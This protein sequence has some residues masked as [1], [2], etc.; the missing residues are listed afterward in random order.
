M[1]T[2]LSKYITPLNTSLKPLII[3][4]IVF[5]LFFQALISTIYIVA[6][7]TTF[8]LGRWIILFHVLLVVCAIVSIILLYSALPRSFICWK[9]FR[10]AKHFICAS[11]ALV[12][13]NIFILYVVNFASNLLF[14]Q[15]VT[16]KVI[17]EYLIGLNEWAIITR[18]IPAGSTILTVFLLLILVVWAGYFVF[19]KKLL[20]R[21]KEDY[22]LALPKS[23]NAPEK[24]RGGG[25]AIGW[26][27]ISLMAVIVIVI[28]IKSS[29]I[30]IR[31]PIVTFFSTKKPSVFE[32]NAHR[33]AVEKRDE[34]IR[35]SF[36]GNPLIS[37]R[38]NVV[39]IVVDCLRA[40]HLPLYGYQRPTTPFLSKL[41]AQGKLKKVELA[42]SSASES[43]GGIL[44]ILA[45]RHYESL[46][47][48]ML[49]IN[50]LL[51]DIGYQT[52]F[53]TSGDHSAIFDLKKYYG[54]SLDVF[55]DGLLSK[56]FSPADDRLIFEGLEEVPNSSGNG[57]FFFFHLMSVHD[58]SVRQREYDYYKPSSKITI[59]ESLFD[60][61]EE[62]DVREKVNDYD[63]GI[64]QTDANINKLFSE[65]GK[66]GYLENSLVVI[67]GDHGQGLGEH[68]NLGHIGCYLYQEHL[69]IPILIYDESEAHYTRLDFAST[70]DIAPT[71]VDSLKLPIPDSWVG[72]SLLGS[73][74][75]RY[76]YH[77]GWTI[78]EANRP[79]RRL[80]IVEYS[81]TAIYKYI[82]TELGSGEELFELHSDPSEKHNL[83]GKSDPVIAHRLKEK[84]MLGPMAEK[85]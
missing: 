76:S 62:R 66:K 51:A 69:R 38:K 59:P 5:F 3:R 31:E 57:A 2:L 36:A 23:Y 75:K 83:I 50:D 18:S 40:D 70:V 82:Y 6:L 67:T 64:L 72:K 46:A 12:L 15:D 32:Y 43:F 54:E 45:S 49:K 11:S 65:L 17:T 81:T 63:N 55:F 47:P 8:H 48:R 4:P 7:A 28:I 35:V 30:P 19:F 26:F 79:P 78:G 25:A 56:K 61:S 85:D 20:E 74:Q 1:L 39:V 21:L 22:L 41:H 53:I 10:I 27:L 58:M 33:F 16:W 29:R 71:I 42:L 84:L 9:Y 44:S 73:Q 60:S 24:S 37:E 80:A 14:H 68:G 13:T 52:Y 34:E 77:L